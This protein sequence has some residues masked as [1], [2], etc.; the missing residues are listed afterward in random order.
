MNKSI[1]RMAF[2]FLFRKANPVQKEKIRQAGSTEMKGHTEITRLNLG[3]IQRITE[4]LTYA[5]LAL[6]LFTS[7]IIPQPVAMAAA[8]SVTVLNF[9]PG[10]DAQVKSS[11]PTKS[12]GSLNNL[13]LLNSTTQVIRTYLKFNITGVNGPVQSA[14]IRLFAYDGSNS[15]GSIYTVSNVYLNTSTPWTEAGLNWQN[16]PTLGSAPLGA[17]GA[18]ANGIWVEYDVTAAIQGNGTYSFGLTSPSTNSIYFNS[19]EAAASQPLLVI[20]FASS[21]S[22]LPTTPPLLSA[23][24]VPTLVQPTI[25]VT[26]PI[27][28]TVA[29][30]VTPTPISPV[31]TSTQ[32]PP[33]ATLQPTFSPPQSTGNGMWISTSVLMGLPTSGSS[34]DKMHSAAYGSWDTADL[35]NQDNKHDI[36]LLAGALI[37]ARTGDPALRSKVRDEIIAAKRT[38]DESSEWQTTNG[39]LAAGRQLGAYVISADLID[40]K[41][42][43]VAADN[44]FRSWLATIRTTNIG[45]HS[46]WKSITFTCENA[47]ANW[48]AFACASRIAA[49]IYLGDTADVNRSASVIRS[50]LGER[51]AYPADAPGQGGYFQHTS[52][53]DSSWACDEATWT[54]IN[55]ACVKSGVN[56]DGAV[57]EDISRG[58]GCCVPQALGTSYS[59]ETLQGLFFSAELLYRTG[60]YGDPYNWSNQALKRALDFMQRSGWDFITFVP[61]LANAHYGTAY[62]QPASGNE[63]IMSWG[64]WLYQK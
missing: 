60:Q 15:G 24:P 38:L 61:W 14:K 48:G 12:Y 56:L 42:Y 58:G 34:W 8:A 53:Y 62:P 25:V 6:A 16:A 22:T 30:T 4:A 47:A 63:R 59:K 52:S 17:V 43:D 18:V 44:E 57:V 37:Y 41:N 45:T 9:T 10:E 19:T 7:I 36:K 50:F 26:V 27:S 31:S 40:L 1:Y 5:L 11:S 20:E 46:R 51:N 55:P 21:T 13:R 2:L 49:S 39:V 32:P 64:D 35:K 3:T 28:N 33:A 54:G 29:P 23:S